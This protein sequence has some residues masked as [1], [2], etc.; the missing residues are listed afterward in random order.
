MTRYY[1]SG[2]KSQEEKKIIEKRGKILRGEEN[3]CE[4]G[5]RLKTIR[6]A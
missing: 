2:G 1:I 4:K 5:K 3:H 6:K